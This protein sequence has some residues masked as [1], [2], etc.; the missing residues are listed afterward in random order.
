MGLTTTPTA[1]EITNKLG[2]DGLISPTNHQGI[3]LT[4]HNQTL[5]VPQIFKVCACMLLLLFTTTAMLQAQTT[6]TWTDENNYDITWYTDSTTVANY[7]I[8]TPQQLAGLAVLVNC[9]HEKT[10]VSFSDKTVTLT[11]DIDLSGKL[12]TPI[13]VGSSCSFYGTFSGGSHTI[14]NMKVDMTVDPADYAGFFGC[15][16]AGSKV[17]NVNVR[18]DIAI[19]NNHTFFYTYAGG[20]VGYSN[21]GTIQNCS[22]IGSVSSSSDSD[23]IATGGIVGQAAGGKVCNNY[24]RGII[25][26]TKG[27]GH[28]LGGIVG[29]YSGYDASSCIQNNYFQG[30]FCTG[31]ATDLYKGC[32]V[33]HNFIALI[34]NIQNNYWQVDGMTDPLGSNPDGEEIKNNAAFTGTDSFT[35]EV[36]LGSATSGT[37]YTSMLEILNAWREKQTSYPGNSMFLNWKVETGINDN[38]PFHTEA[39]EAPII[40]TQPKDTAYIMNETASFS[41]TA[42]LL[43]DGALSYQWQLSTNNGETWS[44]IPGA[45]SATYVSETLSY[46]DNKNLVRC[47]LTN[48]SEGKTSLLFS[49]S[50]SMKMKSWTDA[51]IF[52]I[53]WYTEHSSENEFVITSAQELAG[54]A[55]LV[56]GLHEYSNVTFSGKTIILADD[57]N[58]SGKLWTPIGRGSS[59][60]F[61]GTFSGGNRTIINMVVDI[62]SSSHVYAGL[63]G[64]INTNGK[65]ENVNVEGDITATLSSTNH[66][67]AGGIAGYIYS[68]IIQNC[69]YIGT[70]SGSS[71]RDIYGGGIVGCSHSGTIRSCNTSC[72]V[73]VSTENQSY[74]G[75]IAAYNRAGKI[76]NNYGRGTLKTTGTRT[77]IGGIAGLHDGN[78]S[79]PIQNNYFEGTFST[80][81]SSSSSSKGGI[82]GYL[83]QYTSF[84]IQNNYWQVANITAPLGSYNSSAKICNNV[85]F[86]GTGTLP[87]TYLGS[88][89]TGT[90]YTS[91]LAILN[92]WVTIQNPS[93]GYRTWDQCTSKNDGLPTFTPLHWIDYPD[94]SWYTADGTSY[95]ISSPNQFA[96]LSAIVNNYGNLASVGIA[97]ETFS[98]KT[99]TLTDGINLSG[100]LW[101]PIG[102][103]SNHFEGTFAGAEKTIRNMEV[104]IT[105]S[106]SVYAG[107]FGYIGAGGKVEKVNV[108]GNI[109]VTTPW[110]V[111]VGG[112]AG[113]NESIIQNCSY[114]GNITNSSSAISCSGG[115]AGHNEPG[116]I[117]NC[118]YIGDM[119]CRATST[120]VAGGITGY[121]YMGKINNNYAR[122][123]IKIFEKISSE[124]SLSIGGI[125][126]DNYGEVQNNYFEGSLP[127]K[128]EYYSGFTENYGGIVGYN[129]HVIAPLQN[130]YWKADAITSPID[131]GTTADNIIGNNRAFTDKDSLPKTYLGAENTGTSYTSMLAIL[132]AWQNTQTDYPGNSMYMSW[133]TETDK[134][135][136]YPMHTASLGVPVILTHPKD[137]AYKMDEI[138]SFSITATSDLGTLSYQ[139]Q[140]STDNGAT[141]NNITGATTNVYTTG[142]LNYTHSGNLVSCAAIHTLDGKVSITYSNPAKMQME[143]W[144]DPGNFNI[145]WYTDNLSETTFEITTAQQLAGLSVLV[146]GMHGNQP[147]NFYNKTI[148]LSADINLCGKL[149]TPIGIDNN[150]HP[151]QGA[152]SGG[153]RTISNMEVNI[154]RSSTVYAGLFGY[155]DA[156]GKVENVNVEGNITAATISKNIY[157]GGIVGY[158][159][160]GTI[161]NCSY[162][163]NV[164]A[165][166]PSYYLPFSSVYAGGI[167]GGNDSGIIQNCSYIGNVT[168]TTPS[169]YYDSYSY[170]HLGGIVGDNYNGKIYNNYA[171]G[172]VIDPDE[173]DYYIGGI[174]GSHSGDASCPIQ[175]NYFKGSISPSQSICRS[176]IVGYNH[177]PSASIQN[178]YWQANHIKEPICRT[179][180]TGDNIANNKAFTD[181]GTLPPTYLATGTSGDDSYTSM[182]AILNAWVAAQTTPETYNTWYQR[183]SRN[184]GLPTFTPLHWID[185]PDFSWYT[186]SETSYTIS[187]PN[188]LAGLAAIVNN[189]GNLASAGITSETF[190]GKTITLANDINLI[191]KLWTP[192][193]TDLNRFNGTFS[194]AEKT[195]RNMEVDI[196]AN[197][198]SAGLFAYIETGGVVEKLHVQGNVD[199]STVSNSYAGGIVGL[200]LGIIQNCS[201]TGN[202]SAYGVYWTY[203]GGIAGYNNDSGIIQNCSFYKGRI[204]ST[205]SIS[206]SCAGGIVGR[207]NN[208]GII[209]NCTVS[210]G[211]ISSNFSFYSAYIGGIVGYNN[212]GSIY[213]NYARGCVITPIEKLRAGGIAGCHSGDTTYPIQN[214]YFEGT[215]STVS[216]SGIGGVVGYNKTD[217]AAIRNNYWKESN[218][219][220]VAIGGSSNTTGSNIKNNTDFRETTILNDSISAGD[221]RGKDM[222]KALVAGAKAMNIAVNKTTLFSWEIESSTNNGYP[223]HRLFGTDTTL[224]ALAVNPETLDP[225]FASENHNYDV[226]VGHDVGEIAI[227]AVATDTNATITGAGSK[228]LG[229]G[230]N[231]FNIVVTAESGLTKS[232]YT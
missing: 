231:S 93:T 214:N 109:K 104:D 130:N 131:R 210:E 165:S 174:V 33:G 128:A 78:E 100:K 95:T 146:N 138:V 24:A 201:F 56:N 81:T 61:Q 219:S 124:A 190:S 213:N 73:K 209:R 224:S 192:I 164:S 197:T 175:N 27:T 47:V 137:T 176:G 222:L 65:V 152:F 189:Y 196:T 169:S 154:K 105:S 107:L 23:W 173:Y 134:N 221:Y 50:A 203:A 21:Y 12:W 202:T 111:F 145:T 38:Y 184:D 180:I 99:I 226:T 157:A 218:G 44:D 55:V 96:G 46:N 32:I 5:R 212:N 69:S 205:S 143:T 121:N 10:A 49:N 148:T 133:K 40:I 48:T 88:E 71:Y 22:F 200:S 9:M 19:T 179:Y 57:I 116:T 16:N 172:T 3:T 155:I 18:G 147:I 185:Y 149:W 171:C 59:Y 122:S 101:T 1:F 120:I 91:M 98:G 208:S 163:G 193:G 207:N 139:W 8:S 2:L 168:C 183:E 90:S 52:D 11:D 167:A 223:A 216:N 160:S 187:T 194:G 113:H 87:K 177:S 126:G 29:Y 161:N 229:F 110:S 25:T 28:R 97:S 156:G 150:W 108:E 181:K 64:H 114:I 31:T 66:V 217:S 79:N 182:L 204:T 199:V 140:L 62:T 144:T 13:G 67:Y 225:A 115:I 72:A 191:G 112:I 68:G 84:N 58:L 45:T 220:V 20:I 42:T 63:F 103:K 230:T 153:N 86:T 162:I 94:F 166:S 4:N 136:G 178:N 206:Y 106:S 141:W 123:T 15:I 198:I 37:G 135:N 30:E 232:T 228:T 118:S 119:A 70:V 92:A 188:Q 125:I 39:P 14:S 158:D 215:I 60:S 127:T 77:H 76:Y 151:F 132:N 41:I 89:N 17:E 80:S 75:G 211:N 34:P 43:G 54:L 6:E 102:T 159:S 53:S 227:T 85:A 36:Y 74:A 142:T 186:S 26:V 35:A 82:V 195:I 117:R 170:A 129:N 51:G 83:P 7:H